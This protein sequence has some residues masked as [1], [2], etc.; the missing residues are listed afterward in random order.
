VCIAVAAMLLQP[1]MRPTGHATPSVGSGTRNSGQRTG[2]SARIS[3]C[4]RQAKRVPSPL[5]QGMPAR[6]GCLRPSSKQHQWISN[7]AC[8][9]QRPAQHHKQASKQ[10]SRQASKQASKQARR[11]R[12]QGKA[13]SPA[14]MQ[15]GAQRLLADATPSTAAVTDCPDKPRHPHHTNTPRCRSARQPKE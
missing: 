10:A 14:A 13:Y 3:A 6:Q 11:G 4:K 5:Q 7:T 2:S 1:I 15:R 12:Q 9:N 8:I